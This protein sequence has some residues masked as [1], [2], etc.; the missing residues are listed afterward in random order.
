[1]CNIVTAVKNL[2]ESLFTPEIVKAAINSHYIEV[3]NYIPDKFLTIE[4]VEHMIE[5]NIETWSNTFELDKIPVAWR[6]QK[7]CEYAFKNSKSNIAVIP[8]EYITMNMAETI[9]SHCRGN[10]DILAYIPESLWDAKLAYMALNHYVQKPQYDYATYTDTGIRMTVILGYVPARIKTKSFYWNMLEELVLK[11]TD[12]LQIIPNRYKTKVFYQLLAKRDISL[13][14]AEYASYEVLYAALHSKLENTYLYREDMTRRYFQFLDDHLAD[15]LIEKR[16]YLFSD[17]PKK[18]KTAKRL[19]I[20]L[21]NSKH[22]CDKYFDPE[23]EAYLLTIDV[24]KAFVRRGSSCPRFPDRVW[25]QKFVDYC[26]KHGPTF[27]WFKHMPKKFQT[28]FNTQAAFNYSAYNIYSFSKRFITPQMAKRCWRE[29]SYADAVPEHFISEFV[30]QTGLP[31]TFYG[32]ETSLFLL[33]N[34][35]ISHTYCK[36]GN[37][38][39]GYY[40]K[41]QYD[42]NSA[43]LIMTRSES[44]Y[45]TPERVFEVLIGT[46]H[47]TWLE[48]II[49]EQDPQFVKPQVEKSL[50][51]VQ[52]LCYYGVDKIKDLNRTEIFRNTFMGETIGYCARRRDLTYH[53]DSCETLIEGLKYKIRGMAVP[54]NIEDDLTAYTADMLHNKFGFCYTGMTAF[55]TDYGLDMSKA[56]TSRQMRQIVNE[57]GHK[58][59]IKMYSRELK[60]INVI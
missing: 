22:S 57:I 37:T 46:Y 26:M 1:M 19:V 15:H 48:K 49:S 36:I 33:K 41:D 53:S 56:Y 13:V 12:I 32:G 7:I 58:P 29:K 20:A 31:E 9:V 54:D 44:K 51:A 28:S 39:I 55:A 17:L 23:T 60:Q 35:R 25:T 10:Y 5:N 30:K 34:N 42:S 52:A 11:T 2:P 18:F 45:C 47:R 43:R 40:L 24:C 6:T 21:D 27:N 16:P 4:M 3:L 14:P 38:Y 8:Q 50:R 59:S